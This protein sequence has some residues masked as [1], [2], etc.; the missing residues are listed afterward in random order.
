M[1]TSIII[2]ADGCPVRDI[3][4]NIAKKNKMPALIVV[5]INHII[6]SNYAKVVTVDKGFDSVDFKI[7]A[8]MKA[9]DIVI[10]Q[11]YGLASLVLSKKGY[12]MNQNGM[13]YT[14][15]NIDML[16]LN[17]HISKNIRKAGGKTKGPAKRK[18]EDDVHFTMELEK[19]IKKIRD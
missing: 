17:R 5:D 6:R 1:T 18:R 14:D 15:D 12:A 10:T 11:D 4:V 13:L 7:V 3:S 19:L 8:L 9:G 2:D 16:L